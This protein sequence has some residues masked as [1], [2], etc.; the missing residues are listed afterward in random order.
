MQSLQTFTDTK[1]EGKYGRLIE[2]DAPLSLLDQKCLTKLRWNCHKLVLIKYETGCCYCNDYVSSKRFS[3][4]Y[5]GVLI[6]WI[7]KVL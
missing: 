5:Y 7:E 4:T 2:R 3:E 6:S 1:M